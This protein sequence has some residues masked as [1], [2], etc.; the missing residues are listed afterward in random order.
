VAA[1]LIRRTRSGRIAPADDPHGVEEALVDLYQ[2]WKAGRSLPDQDRELV[3][4][5]EAR[6]QARDWASMLDE[7]IASR[8]DRSAEQVS[9]SRR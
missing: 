9:V 8:R 2:A 3:A 7:L 1:D 6:A 5:Y 4:N